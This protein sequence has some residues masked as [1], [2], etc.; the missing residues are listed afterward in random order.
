MA[1][2]QQKTNKEQKKPKKDQS[3]PK[4]LASEPIRTSVVTSIIPKGKIKKVG[5]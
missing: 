5:Q 2:G 1:K 3:A 4:A